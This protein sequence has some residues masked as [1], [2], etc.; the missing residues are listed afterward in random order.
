[1][2]IYRDR[3]WTNKKNRNSFDSWRSGEEKKK[4]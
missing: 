3:N 2:N 4:G 1:M